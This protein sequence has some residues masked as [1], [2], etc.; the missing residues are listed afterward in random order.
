MRERRGRREAGLGTEA[1]AAVVDRRRM[2]K[3]REARALAI[4]DES[5]RVRS[6]ETGFKD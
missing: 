3:R 4:L 5:E 2:T 6:G 1:A